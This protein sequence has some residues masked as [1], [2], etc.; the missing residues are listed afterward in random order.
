MTT[1]LEPP[2]R[3][4]QKAPLHSLTVRD[5]ERK[6]ADVIVDV[7]CEQFVLMRRLIFGR[8]RSY[9]IAWARQIAMALTYEF[10]AMTTPEVGEFFGDR[11]HGTVLWAIKQVK[12]A[13]VDAERWAQLTRVREALLAPPH[14]M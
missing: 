13:T 3:L 12:D 14:L 7:V 11:D 6:K 4:K 2:A 5:V 10:T 9:T 1:I 8:R